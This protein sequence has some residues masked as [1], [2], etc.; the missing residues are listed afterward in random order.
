MGRP[1]KEQ[2]REQRAHD[3]KD[4]PARIP[5][6]VGNKLHV[7]SSLKK[8]GF[9]YYW[10][11]DRKGAIEQMEAAGAPIDISHSTLESVL[12]S[13]LNALLGR[14]LIEEKD[15]LYRMKASEM[16]LV[17]YYANSISQW[18]DE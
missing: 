3:N 8:E 2:S 10:A 11:I 18:R 15:N 12:G 4:R 1:R 9:F 6:S 16:D 13:A 7:P 14:G 17:N 5:M